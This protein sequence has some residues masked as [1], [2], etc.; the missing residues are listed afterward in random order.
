MSSNC[1]CSR[2]ERGRFFPSKANTVLLRRPWTIIGNS[3]YS[4]A[5][6]K[7]NVTISNSSSYSVKHG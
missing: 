6:R 7:C 1:A 2:T 4:S 5:N 3:M